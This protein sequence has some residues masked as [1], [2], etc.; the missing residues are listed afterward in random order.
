MSG[1][2]IGYEAGGMKPLISPLTSCLLLLTISCANMELTRTEFLQGREGLQRAPELEVAGIPDAVEFGASQEVDWSGYRRLRIDPVV[3]VS[4]V[5]TV[6]PV[7]SE[8]DQ[9]YLTRKYR[10]QL[11]RE[12]GK[13]FELVDS[14]VPG[15]LRLRAAITDVDLEWVW[16]N[17]L[18]VLLVVPPDM[19][20]IST[21][22]E[23]LDAESGER[24]LAMTA[25]REGTIFL[26]LEAFHRWGHAKHGMKKWA[27]LLRR[28]L[29][30]LK[31]PSS[32]A[33]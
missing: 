22:I 7:P 12:L 31:E 28:E 8:A 10:D 1:V 33:Q 18:G 30:A 17:V 6:H 5:G 15:T 4:G 23:L 11:A 3:F 29:A 21:E 14:T 19:G 26:I 25:Y 32:S 20:G 9:A 27:K 16:L 2:R 24:L 13:D